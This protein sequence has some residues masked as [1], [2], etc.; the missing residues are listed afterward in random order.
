MNL[1]RFGDVTD[2]DFLKQALGLVAKE[3]VGYT[4][5][6]LVAFCTL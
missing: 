4:R 3:A 1:R 6:L 5:V 2:Y